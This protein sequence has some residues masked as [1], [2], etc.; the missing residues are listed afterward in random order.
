MMERCAVIVAALTECFGEMPLLDV[1]DKLAE[2]E[3]SAVEICLHEHGTQLK[4]SQVAE[5]QDKAIGLCRDTHRLDLTGYSVEPALGGPNYY[6]H[7]QACC[8]LA[9]A[10]KVSCITVPSG[11]LGTPF[12]E[13]VERLRR[14]VDIANEDSQ[15]FIGHVEA[16]H[17]ARMSNLTRCFKAVDTPS[18]A[19]IEDYFSSLDGRQPNRSPAAIG[20]FQDR[21]RNKFC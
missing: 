9:K 17:L 4:P 15:H 20:D 18:R 14:L 21:F 12:N 2:L 1:F 16:D 5:N 19:D 10:T 6:Q 11:E 13:E 3:Y 8:R 7:F